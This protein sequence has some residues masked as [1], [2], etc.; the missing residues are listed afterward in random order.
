MYGW[1]GNQWN[2]LNKLWGTYESGWRNN[3]QNPGSTAYGIAQFLDSTWAPYGPK[4]SNAG[5]QIKYGLEY[6]HDRYKDPIH[7]LQFEL[8]HYPALVRRWHDQR[9]A[10]MALVGERGP[11]LVRLSGGQQMTNASRRRT[12][13]RAPHAKPGADAVVHRHRSQ[14]RARWPVPAEQPRTATGGKAEVNLNL[15]PGAIVVHT[16]GSATDV[17]NNIRQ[18][19]EGITGP[20]PTTRPCRRSW[21][22]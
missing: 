14:P 9:P 8:S 10:G 1:T 13:S 18:I 21:R 20:W 15:P 12:S 11:E 19:M 22:G 5:L 3:A 4:T 6:I 16:K 17:S 2:A 7:A